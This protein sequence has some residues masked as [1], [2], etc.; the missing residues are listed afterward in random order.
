M[1]DYISANAGII[2]L[3]FFVSVFA[4]VTIWSFRPS[5][6]KKIESYKYIPLGEE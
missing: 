5:V 3:I 2:G 6:K 1:M 4:L